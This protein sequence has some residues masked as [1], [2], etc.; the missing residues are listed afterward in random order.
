VEQLGQLTGVSRARAST[1][2]TKLAKQGLA[3]SPMCV[4]G[5]SWCLTGAGKAAAMGEAPLLDPLDKT[6]LG[7]LAQAA[8]GRGRL[9][10]RCAVSEP[11]ITRRCRLLGERFLV[12]C[13]GR[14][15][16]R[17]TRD[18]LAAL[19]GDIPRREPWLKVEAISAA[20]SRE[21]VERTNIPEMSRAEKSQHSAASAA[22]AKLNRRR[23]QNTGG[24]MDGDFEELRLTG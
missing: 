12:N 19:G 3:T 8:M 6:I 23:G 13:D 20:L 7:V 4:P 22:K 15:F 21:V 17:I 5:R 16:Y 11:T 1:R 10:R 2:L 18:G 14:G 9:S 24:V